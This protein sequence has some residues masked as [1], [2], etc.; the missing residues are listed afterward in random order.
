MSA[1]FLKLRGR[2]GIFYGLVA[3]LGFAFFTWFLDAI[4]LATAHAAYPFLKLIS[5]LLVTLPIFIL[6][7]WLTTKANSHVVGLLLWGILSLWA[8]TASFLAQYD[9]LPRWYA[10]MQEP[11]ATLVKPSIPSYFTALLLTVGAILM[12]FAFLIA[13]L[14]EIN[15]IESTLASSSG[16]S[17]LIAAVI[18]VTLMGLAGNQVDTFT[19]RNSRVS[20]E[21]FHELITLVNSPEG[22][23]MDEKNKTKRNFGA[24][25]SLGIENLTKPHRFFLIKDMTGD[26]GTVD[27]MIELGD[28]WG[29][30]SASNRAASFCSPTYFKYQ[31]HSYFL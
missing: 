27:L 23:A 13:G 11:V 25:T 18:I 10:L 16:G 4:G 6:V 30:C 20:I 26:Y 7:G 12:M 22:Q 9:F 28:T 17:K 14:L 5:G 3:G 31:A 8:F 19:Y 29:K 21:S 24:V 1:S 15:L 2:Y